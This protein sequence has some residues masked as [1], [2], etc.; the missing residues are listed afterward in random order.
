MPRRDVVDLMPLLKASIEKRRSSVANGSGRRPAARVS[1][2][3]RPRGPPAGGAI[4]KRVAQPLAAYRDDKPASEVVRETWPGLRRDRRDGPE[5]C[6]A[7][8]AA[9]AR[10]A[11]P[12]PR[13]CATQSQA[14]GRGAAAKADEAPDPRAARSG[15]APPQLFAARVR[16][17]WSVGL[18]R[19]RRPA[20]VTCAIAPFSVK[21]PCY[22]RV[23]AG[24]VH[25]LS[26]TETANAA[27]S[28][29]RFLLG[30]RVLSGRVR[31]A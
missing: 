18:Y 15:G 24:W 4:G 13:R 9:P 6:A 12:P 10:H 31:A 23:S 26:G 2:S 3:P 16:P 5:A 29:A 21:T 1:R 20:T 28:Q 27:G 19:Y 25:S 7:C 11:D 17:E 22:H 14:A 8:A 30:T